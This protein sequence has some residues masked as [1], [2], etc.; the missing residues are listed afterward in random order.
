[1]DIQTGT[2][3]IMGT[4]GLSRQHEEVITQLMQDAQL[5]HDDIQLR[6][7]IIGQSG[8]GTVFG[9][10]KQCQMEIEARSTNLGRLDRD[11]ACRVAELV[12]ARV[13]SRR[14]AW[15]AKS[16]CE[17][18]KAQ[19]EVLQLEESEGHT[20]RQREHLLREIRIILDIAH[21]CQEQL[22]EITP[23]SRHAFERLFWTSRLKKQ[24][25]LSLLS[26]GAPE[27]GLIETIAYLPE[28][29]LAEVLSVIEQP[30]VLVGL[31]KSL[32]ALRGETSI[33]DEEGQIRMLGES[34]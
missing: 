22:G 5:Y 28:S 26:A 11:H 33:I 2:R 20:A 15:T 21:V 4:R 29:M 13:R 25:R 7:F 19:Q 30:E 6:Y 32:G 12:Y 3:G 17:R 10:W 34:S 18:A 8:H 1:M 31:K 9:M 14:W 16:K 23:E 27:P 24:L